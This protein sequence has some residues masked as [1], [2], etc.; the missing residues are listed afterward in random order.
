M[1]A[2][3]LIEV[4]QDDVAVRTNWEFFVA[5][6]ALELLV[7]AVGPQLR[8]RGFHWMVHLK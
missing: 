3:Q 1:L 4:C 6:V 8:R 5:E 2:L 7:G